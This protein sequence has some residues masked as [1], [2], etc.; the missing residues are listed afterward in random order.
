MNDL[1]A[2][3]HDTPQ[4]PWAKKVKVTGSYYWKRS[5]I[6]DSVEMKIAKP[7]ISATILANGRITLEVDSRENIGNHMSKSPELTRSLLKYF[8][9]ADF[10]SGVSS[11]VSEAVDWMKGEPFTDAPWGMDVRGVLDWAPGVENPPQK[12]GKLGQYG[13]GMMKQA[14]DDWIGTD[15]RF[16]HFVTPGE[17]HGLVIKWP[18]EEKPAV[19]VGYIDGFVAD[20]QEDFDDWESYQGWN[21]TFENGFLWALDYLKVFEQNKI[22]E[23]AVELIEHDPDLMWPDLVEKLLPIR[24]QLPADLELSLMVWMERRQIEL[25]KATKQGRFW[26]RRK[27]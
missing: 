2:E 17:D 24:N 5:G 7:H 8:K 22:P 19:F 13:S 9:R 1:Y 23:W 15:F 12:I 10:H 26:P 6:A 11:F 21:E 4:I 27:S 25:E 16:V 3:N 20:N 14:M 18:D